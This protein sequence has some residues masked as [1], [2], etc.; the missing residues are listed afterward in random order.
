MVVGAGAIGTTI[1]CAM[2]TALADCSA[3][4]DTWREGVF[5][6]H[7]DLFLFWDW[8]ECIVHGLTTDP[9]GRCGSCGSG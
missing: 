6:P 7:P 3:N 5:Q 1:G 2:S 8:R 9:V 4:F